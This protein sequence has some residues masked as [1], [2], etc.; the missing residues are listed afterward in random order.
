MLA[1]RLLFGTL[2]TVLFM[3]VVLF[4]GWLDGS[5][6]A[7][8]SD[9]TAV[10]GTLLCVLVFALITASN[11]E[12]SSLALARNVRILVP[13]S[14]L[15]SI[16]VAG[17]WYWLELLEAPAAPFV[18]SL[19]AFSLLGLF[20]YQYVRFGTSGVLA[21]CGASCLAIVYLGV[22]SGF[23]IAIRLDFGLWP[24]L[25]FIFAVKCSDIGAYAVGSLLGR[26]KFS[27]SV[28]PGKS[29]EGM[30]GAV[31]GGV[32]VS[33]I[34]GVACDIMVWW[35]AVAFGCGAALV[36][37]MGDLAESLIKREAEYKDSADMVPG[38]G[39]IL[40]IVDSPLAAAP[41]AYLFFVFAAQGRH[42]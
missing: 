3:S 34:F 15:G 36:G 26:H 12:L 5:L 16:A 39:G 10:Q 17:S 7:T 19:L 29:W 37:Q 14:A 33:F 38:F 18:F 20:L 13:V 23:V 25:M 27:P 30:G 32:I 4:D 2:M 8:A 28:S 40:D 9:D 35:S 1:Y 41:F 31:L 11:V 21:N 42:W 22:L 24:M 6:T